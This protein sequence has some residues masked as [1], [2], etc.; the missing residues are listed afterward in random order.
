MIGLLFYICCFNFIAFKTNKR[1]TSNQIHHIWTF[2]IAF[3]FTF[4]LLVEF[5]YCQYWY[6]GKEVEWIGLLPHILLIPPVN[7]IFLNWFPFAE[8]IG[9]QIIYLTIWILGM[10]IFEELTLL[11]EPWGFFHYGEWKLWYSAIIDPILLFLLLGYYKWICKL[12]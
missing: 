6:F 9:K 1:L 10:L 7:M 2:T 5:K 3:Q 4:D 8:K 11:P 12:T